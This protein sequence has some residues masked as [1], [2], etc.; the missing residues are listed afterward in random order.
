MNEVVLVGSKPVRW[1]GASKKEIQKLPKEVRQ[2]FGQAIYDAQI[3]KKHPG[4]KPLK[5]FGGAGVLEVIE[6]ELGS[7][8]RAVYTVKFADIVYVL[9]VFQKKSKSGRKTPKE[10][11]DKIKSRFQEAEKDYAKYIEQ[12][13]ESAS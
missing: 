6:D 10:E 12:R 5:G 8:Y 9:S 11:I 1:V 13:K 7:T 2:V 4:A 3:G